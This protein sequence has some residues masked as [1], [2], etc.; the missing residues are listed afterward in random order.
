MCFKII[1][2]KNPML[3]HWSLVFYLQEAICVMST[4]Q[5]RLKNKCTGGFFDSSTGVVSNS[6]KHI[7]K[8]PYS[9]KGIHDLK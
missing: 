1:F 7:G 2:E 8:R 3:A 4:P 6:V 5:P 9:H